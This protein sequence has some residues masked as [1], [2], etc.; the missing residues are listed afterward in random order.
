M[1]DT[2][3]KT[4]YKCWR[5]LLNVSIL[6][7]LINCKEKNQN[8]QP[9]HHYVINILVETKTWQ[10][11]VWVKTQSEYRVRITQ[12]D[13]RSES[14]HVHQQHWMEGVGCLFTL[15]DSSV[16][17]DLALGCFFPVLK[18]WI[19]SYMTFC[20]L[21]S[22]FF[23]TFFS[24]LGLAPWVVVQDALCGHAGECLTEVTFDSQPVMHLPQMGGYCLSVAPQLETPGQ[25]DFSPTL[26]D[27]LEHLKALLEC[28]P[29]RP[30][31]ALVIPFSY[32]L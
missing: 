9:K 26:E 19:F 12:E 15:Q 11:C 13:L 1:L 32:S 4:L 31:M 18:P 5:I 14:T 29:W 8:G 23:C 30:T 20:L 24:M 2:R 21:L 17:L 3:D 22:F 28:S 6:T 10:L 25:N 16:L 7:Y 27:T